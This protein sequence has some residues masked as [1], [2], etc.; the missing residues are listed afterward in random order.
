M[1]RERCSCGAEFE[2]DED[3]AISLVKSWRESHRHQFT[4]TGMVVTDVARSDVAP[5][6][7][8]PELHIGFRGS[9]FDE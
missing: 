2:T 4:D 3:K 7:L 5:D 1:I 9:E 6:A 8:F